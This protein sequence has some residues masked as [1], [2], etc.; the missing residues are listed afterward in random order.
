MRK[1]P[2]ECFP[3]AVAERLGAY[4]KGMDQSDKIV[5]RKETSKVKV[6]NSLKPRLVV[7]L[8]SE[9]WFGSLEGALRW[10]MAHN[11]GRYNICIASEYY[12]MVLARVP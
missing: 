9:I 4:V 11:Q 8:D 2:L 3:Q 7:V 5:F 12:V 1:R 6:R 10:L